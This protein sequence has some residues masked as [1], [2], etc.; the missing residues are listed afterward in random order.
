MPRDDRQDPLERF[1]DPQWSEEQAAS[2][3]AMQPERSPDPNDHLSPYGEYL[4]TRCDEMFRDSIRD[5]ASVALGR[6]LARY[7]LAMDMSGH[8]HLARSTCVYC[9]ARR[10][11]AELL[12]E[13]Q[14]EA[15]DE[16]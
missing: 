1:R 4:R 8:R 3:Q 2:V 16:R 15:T 11:A 14:E 13:K 9:A 12:G 5:A 7:V 10:V 6:S